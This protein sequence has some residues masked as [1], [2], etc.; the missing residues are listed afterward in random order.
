MITQF[1]IYFY[2]ANRFL[3]RYLY[4]NWSIYY[5]K[6]LF[7]VNNVRYGTG[8]KTNGIPV[9]DINKNCE[10]IIGNLFKIN[11]GLHFNRIGRQQP[12]F[13][14]ADFGGIISIG[15]NVGMS[16]VAII[17]HKKI[18]I[19]NNVRIGGNT[20]I[21]DTD[22]HNLDFY[23]RTTVPEDLTTVSKKAVII[24]D[25][26]FIGAHSTILK[27]VVIGTNAVIGAGSVITKSIPSNEIWAGNP[28]R[29]IKN[30][31]LEHSANFTTYAESS[32]CI[33]LNDVQTISSR[34]NCE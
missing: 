6:Y 29:F 12:C 9:I 34:P 8:F 33:T 27:G 5:T 13:F 15:N 21:Y 1:L 31:Y 3:F 32:K 23:K 25:N 11:N 30:N 7:L 10:L 20:V 26:V 24:E 19:G 2:R 14:I 18:S 4:R 22:F 16:G 28:A 17:C